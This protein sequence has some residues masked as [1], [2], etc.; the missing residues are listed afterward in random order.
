MSIDNINLL[1]TD[2]RPWPL[3]AGR[4]IYYQEWNNALFLHWKVPANDLLPLIPAGLTLDLYDNCAWVSLVAFTMEKIRPRGIP[5]IPAISDFHEINIRTYVTSQHKPGVY[6][7]NIEAEKYLSVKIARYLSGLPYEKATIERKFT[8]VG[9]SYAS[10]N[11]KKGFELSI[12]FEPVAH[13]EHTTP[14]DQWLTERYCLYLNSKGS[15][16]RYNIHHRPWTFEQMYLNDTKTT[17]QIGNIS[18]AHPPDLAHYSNG[19]QVLAWKREK[20]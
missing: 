6:F 11:S 14:L 15:L 1:Y 13:V 8:H 7:L 12:G 19:V 4:W 20:V 2:H 9:H 17:Y 10:V 18:L 16:Y 3:P 5:A